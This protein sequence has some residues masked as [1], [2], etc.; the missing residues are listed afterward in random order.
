MALALVEQELDTVADEAVGV[1]AADHLV[2][3]LF[4]RRL[5]QRAQEEVPDIER[6]RKTAAA[7]SSGNSKY[8]SRKSQR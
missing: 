1:V 2:E 8:C 3:D 4:V 7:N 6:Q 5:A